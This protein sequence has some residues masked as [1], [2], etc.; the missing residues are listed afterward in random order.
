MSTNEISTNVKNAFEAVRKTYNSVNK[1]FAAIDIEAKENGLINIISGQ[2]PF[3][4]YK[5]DID[6]EGWLINYFIKL[7]QKADSP[8]H[9]KIEEMKLDEFIYGIVISFEINPTLII[10]KYCFEVENW[11][12]CPPVSDDGSCYWPVQLN[13][14][15]KFEFNRKNEFIKSIPKNEDVRQRHRLI[16]YAIFKEINLLDI[17]A[18]NFKEKIFNGFKELPDLEYFN[19]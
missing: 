18:D 13:F 8:P 3:V 14:G 16:K 19:E 17:N 12:Y 7:Y 6:I 5:S 15:N 9:P 10:A 11:N 4:R 2:R 1:L